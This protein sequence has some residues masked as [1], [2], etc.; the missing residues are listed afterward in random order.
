MSDIIAETND[1]F[2]HYHFELLHFILAQKLTILEGGL[3]WWPFCNV[4]F[5][6]TEVSNIIA[7]SNDDFPHYHFELLNLILAQKLTI[8]EGGLFCWPFCNSKIVNF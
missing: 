3:Y 7:E 2:P 6:I 8:L 5:F 4:S 1:D